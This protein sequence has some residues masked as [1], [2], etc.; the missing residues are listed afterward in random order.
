MQASVSASPP[1]GD[2]VADRV[3]VVPR[4]ERTD[5]SLGDGAIAGLVGPVGEHQ[6]VAASGIT[7]AV[8][9]EERGE[10]SSLQ[11]GVGDRDRAHGVV[12]EGGARTEQREVLGLDRVELVDR[13]D[14]VAGDRTEHR[15][16]P[17]ERPAALPAD[18]ASRERRP[19]PP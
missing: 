8:T 16:P 3:L 1:R 17:D 18:P 9:F 15:G 12:G 4:L 10:I 14:D 11:E 19:Q 2:G 6:A 13:S 5:Q 7:P